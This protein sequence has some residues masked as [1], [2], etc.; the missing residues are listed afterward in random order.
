[1]ITP[2]V[3]AAHDSGA[4]PVTFTGV[5]DHVAQGFEALGV[6][7][8]VIG[9]VW[10]LWHG[11]AA[12]RRSRQPAAGYAALKQLFGSALLLSVEIF[13]AADLL[14]TVTV[15]P[16]L[17]NVLVLGLLVL[18]RTFLSFSLETEIEGVLP[19]RRA[20]AA[21]AGTGRK[22]STAASGDDAP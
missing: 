7:V 18:I 6:L 15:A 14:R 10:A 22:A 20:T 16:T 3:A 11:A 13:V 9:I 17:D 19:W 2:S 4:Q 21:G 12:W 5:M 1:L 8:L